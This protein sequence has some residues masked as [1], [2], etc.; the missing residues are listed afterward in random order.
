[1]KV[2]IRKATPDDTAQVAQLWQKLLHHH[3]QYSPCFEI[4]EENGDRFLHHG[5]KTGTMK[6]HNNGLLPYCSP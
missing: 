6:A 4:L 5:R 2:T 3:L 1:M